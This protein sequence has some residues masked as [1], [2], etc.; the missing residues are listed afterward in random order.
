MPA[1]PGRRAA[2]SGDPRPVRESPGTRS[3]ESGER[4][5][6]ESC[7]LRGISGLLLGAAPR[8]SRTKPPYV[9]TGSS[10]TATRGVA[11]WRGRIRTF[12]LLIQRTPDDS[13]DGRCDLS[14]ARTRISVCPAGNQVEHAGR[15]QVNVRRSSN[16]VKRTYRGRRQLGRGAVPSVPTTP[17]LAPGPGSSNAT[18]RSRP[19]ARIRPSPDCRARRNRRRPRGLERGRWG[20]VAIAR[21]DNLAA[22]LE[23]T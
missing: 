1:A 5:I 23:I 19:P 14:V 8:S 21:D 16:S 18:S 17:G 7:E 20:L 6:V 15:S 9:V 3:G 13:V 2:R 11:G 22:L 10:W 12:D 4:S